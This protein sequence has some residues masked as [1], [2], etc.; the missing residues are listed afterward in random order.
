MTQILKI[1][2]CK[3]MARVRMVTRTITTTIAVALV[4]DLENNAIITEELKVAGKFENAD[5]KDFQKA[6]KATYPDKIV[7][8]VVELRYE[9]T[10]Y[11]MLET[12]FLKNAQVLPPRGANA[13]DTDDDND[14]IDELIGE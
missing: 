8:K 10:L 13:G 4:A 5:N 1:E 2:R 9:E 6:I 11:G 7:A 12:E 14:I 3:I